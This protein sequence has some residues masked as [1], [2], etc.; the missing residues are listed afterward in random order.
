MGYGE[1]GGAGAWCRERGSSCAGEV[2]KRRPC[3]P[4]ERGGVT[5]GEAVWGFRAQTSCT[6]TLHAI[7]GR[8]DPPQA[9]HW[10]HK[11]GG[12]RTGHSS[13]SNS[14]S[15]RLQGRK[16]SK[17]CCSGSSNTRRPYPTALIARGSSSSTFYT[18][19]STNSSRHL[20]GLAADPPR[21]PHTTAPALPAAAAAS[22]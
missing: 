6:T 19:T 8:T 4:R 20:T 7:P 10:Q 2:R 5:Q 13:N 15:S 22:V 9:T 14:S 21:A 1:A 11:R 12:C 18:N 16:C 3:Q 17:S